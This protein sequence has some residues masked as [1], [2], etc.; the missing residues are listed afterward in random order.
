METLATLEEFERTVTDK[1]IA[2]LHQR[3]ADYECRGVG[4]RDLGDAD[5][6]VNRILDA[7]PAPHLWY[8]QFGAFWV[9]PSS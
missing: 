8:E 2:G 9:S 6:F 3:F 4:V 7:A 1:V 5:Q